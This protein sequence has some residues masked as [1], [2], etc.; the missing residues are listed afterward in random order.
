MRTKLLGLCLLPLAAA[1]ASA[2]EIP[3]YSGE[4]IVVTASRFEQRASQAPVNVTIITQEDI[5]RSA[6]K[7]LPELLAEQA[8]IQ[9]RNADGSPDLAIDMRGFGMTG[10]QNTLV[11][12]DGQRLNDIDLS[13]VKWSAIP[14][15]SIEKIEIIRGGGA[16][17]YGGGATGGTIN[18]VT[19]APRPREKS[20]SAT[21]AV[22]SYD[23][24]DARAT[25]SLGGERAGMFVSANSYESDNYRANNRI[26]Q[27]N[28]E[29]DVRYQTEGGHVGV[30][31]GADDQTLR[32][33]GARTAAQLDSD[34]RG[35]ATPNDY[36]SR[37][38]GHVNLTLNQALG[39]AELAAELSYREK[40]QK[41]FFGDYAFF[42]YDAY[43]ETQLDVL[44]FT[45]RLKIPHT[46]LGPASTLVV[47]LDVADWDYD[48]RRASSPSTI[49]DP[50]AHILATQKNRA[51]YAQNTAT[52][53][54][55]TTLSLGARIH[56]VDYQARDEMNRAAYA[57]A[58]QSRSARAFELGLRH[59]LTG[60]TAL[61]GR[62]GRSFRIATVDEIYN[63]Y[64]GP[65]WDSAITLLEPQTSHDREIGVDW[66]AGKASLRAA[67]YHIDLNNEIHYN[68]LSYTNMNLSPTR[69]YGLELE[70]K[71]ELAQNVA[72]FANYT[73]AVAK[74]REGVYGGVDVA[75]KNIPLVPRHAASAGVS[76][77]MG[78]TTRLSAVANYVGEQYFDNDQD[79]SFGRKMPAYTTADLKLVHREGGWTLTA[80]VN[81]LFDESYFSY[82]IRSR[83]TPGAYNAY[84]MP[85][86]NFTV[87]AGYAF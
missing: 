43:S 33:P 22:G 58:S 36:S 15:E 55:A 72:A 69:R 64:G 21:L 14:L 87:S 17:L 49:G 66:Q 47:G 23:A 4:E 20:G 16:V 10:N 2:E 60:N 45:P 48:S 59:M 46:L 19:R 80:A 57:E 42:F 11:L 76:W 38:G 53:S 3:T 8:G 5:R 30:K 12:L 82:G 40:R 50:A 85:E 56:W 84:P 9:A 51:L 44:S 13:S 73:L 75:G 77:Q 6:A 79:N 63:Q 25:L 81:N 39:K 41:A 61:F 71:R 7:T 1:A 34:P 32:L 86:R 29:A 54:P 27:N 26:R 52:L 70:G 74:F 83:S 78:A 62:L 68:A 24:R 35:T 31:F 67:L 28:L 65:L 18:I 37:D